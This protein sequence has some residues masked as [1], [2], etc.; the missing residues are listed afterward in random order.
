MQ[1]PQKHLQSSL[2]EGLYGLAEL[3]QQLALAKSFSKSCFP[4]AA[5]SLGPVL[6]LAL[7]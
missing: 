6:A 7:C 3:I 2:G 1:S 4:Q 5:A